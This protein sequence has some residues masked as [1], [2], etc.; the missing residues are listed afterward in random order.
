MS[1]TQHGCAARLEG[2]ILVMENV[3]IR[4]TWRWNGGR[5]ATVAI[6]DRASGATLRAEASAPDFEMPGLTVGAPRSATF[7]VRE[8]PAT[9]VL[10]FHLEAVVECVYP[11]GSTRQVFRIF[12]TAPAI[13]LTLWTTCD[14]PART[15]SAASGVVDGAIEDPAL[16][17]AASS[18]VPT[19]DVVPLPGVH[20]RA[21][22]VA[23]HDRTDF[24]NNLVDERQIL[25]YRTETTL[26]GNLLFLQPFSEALPSLFVVKSA[27]CQASQLD[28]P[29]HD[30]MV[31]TGRAEVR[32]CGFT[33]EALDGWV[34]GHGAA[35]GVCGRDET[36]RLAD[37][38]AYQKCLRTM[39]AD[40]DEMIVMNTW[41]DRAQDGRLCER[42][43]LAEIAVAKSLGVTH[44]QLDDGWQKG[45]SH[46]SAFAGGQFP[47]LARMPDFWEPHPER[48]PN[49]LGPVVEAGRQ[50][51]VTVCLWFNPSA[52]DDYASWRQDADVLIG[53]HRRHGITV[54]KI[55]G[56]IVESKRAEMRLRQLFDAVVEASA[57]EV[58]FNLDVTAGRRFGYFSFC[59]YGNVFLENRYTD[60]QNW[61]PTWT[62]R[63]LWQLARY[64]PPERLQIEFLNNRRNAEKYSPDDPLAPAKV[65]FETALCMTLAAQPLA[66]FE[67]TGLARDAHFE[68]ASR[69]LAAYRN[70]AHD[71]H[72]GVILPVGDEPS[73]CSVAGFQSFD[74]TG[75]GW[76]I[77][78]REA[79]AGEA[80]R[81]RLHVKPGAKLTLRPLGGGRA[82]RRVA[83]ADG[84]VKLP[85]CKPWSF[86]IWRVEA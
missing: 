82:L 58:V 42:F 68:A 37:L 59:E 5:I 14:A 56:V 78:V 36:A 48:F 43:A 79:C 69:L 11:R 26:A 45:R 51:G 44:F 20:W 38:R 63:N 49:G 84:C 60:W 33:G 80:A 16:L 1:T 32:G 21:K 72:S 6:E 50:A 29:G 17:A 40:R 86:G 30:F 52:A 34:R 46:N 85:L 10:P 23:F 65:P 75:A 66:W 24:C 73:G 64:L 41:G 4:R 31:R 61:Y 12:E 83:D 70:I 77:L 25:A 62:F 2:D 28:W 13:D 8:R 74:A 55:D 15:A 57:G 19:T 47:D 53:L 67:G 39:R 71:F 9:T 81:V 3:R 22:A 18:A 7:S 35:V 54:F 76:L 27:P